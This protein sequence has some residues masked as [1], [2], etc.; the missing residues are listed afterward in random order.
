[1]HKHTKQQVKLFYTRTC[2]HTQDMLKFKARNS[3]G[4]MSVCVENGG[5]GGSS[6]ELGRC[7]V[8][9]LVLYGCPCRMRG[10]ATQ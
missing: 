2:A 7:V 10:S 6:V 3:S 9:Y 5:G 4:I 8:A 1:M